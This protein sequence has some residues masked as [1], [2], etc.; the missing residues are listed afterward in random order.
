VVWKRILDRFEHV[1]PDDEERR[2]L[3][4]EVERSVII[5]NHLEIARTIQ[6]F[7]HLA[8]VDKELEDLLMAYL[9]HVD[10][11]TSLRTAGIQKDPIMFG[12]PWPKGLFTAI[13]SRLVACQTEYNEIL[14]DN[15]IMGSRPPYSGIAP[16]SSLEIGG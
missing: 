15:G 16:R 12:E 10:V 11:Y 14:R 7:I 5:P 6:S 8:A 13:Q 9:R 1:N 3:A 2:K 4:V